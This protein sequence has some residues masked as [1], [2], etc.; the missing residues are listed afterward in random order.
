VATDQGPVVQSAVLRGELVRLRKE[1]GLTQEQVAADLEWSPSKLIRIE[2]GRSS[3][4]KVD[5]D[6]LLARYG[7]TSESTHERLQLLNR[8]ARER[9]WW[10]K[11]KDDVFPTYLSYV[12]FE[13]GAAFIR[14][15][16]SLFVPG[17]LQTAE[18]AEAVTVN[19][20]DAIRVASIVGLRLQRQ[21][22]L[23][24]RDPRPRQYYVVD[25]AVIRRHVGI[26]KSPDI[27][28]AQLQHIVDRAEQDELV[29]IRVIPFGAG[30]HRGLYGP[31]TLLEFDGG[32]P[33]L[34]YIDAGRGEFASMVMGDDSRLADY[35]DDFELLL[36]DAL[37]ADRSLELIRSV[38]EEM[39]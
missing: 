38:A 14:Q 22:E 13:A 19:S 12:G 18:Y 34:L 5:L 9:G 27:M 8:G 29:T 6:A 26:A 33:D 36:E 4:T 16:Q 31:F 25:E 39:S 17:L 3:I 28:P 23:A 37:S 32:L 15:F 10:D 20:V 21:T 1:S 2:G 11:Y 35:R 7:V 30:A 24:Q